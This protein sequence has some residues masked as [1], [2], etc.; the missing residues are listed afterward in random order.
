MAGPAGAIDVPRTLLFDCLPSVLCVV[1]P[2]SAVFRYDDFVDFD[3]QETPRA[4]PLSAPTSGVDGPAFAY[5]NATSGG[6]HN[7]SG[8]TPSTSK[9]LLGKLH[10][11]IKIRLHIYYR[12]SR[13]R[14]SLGSKRS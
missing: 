2:L 8:R 10:A 6:G 1:P 3:A 5:L 11:Y 9:L 4:Q 13:R 7:S 12:H 14:I